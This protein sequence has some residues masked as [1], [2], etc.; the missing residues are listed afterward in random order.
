MS[1]VELLNQPEHFGCFVY[2][3]H[4]QPL[5]NCVTKRKG[6]KLKLNHRTNRIVFLLNGK[7]TYSF[8]TMVN[9]VFKPSTFRLFP[10]SY[11]VLVHIEED[12]TVLYVNMPSK[13]NFC[14][15]FSLEMLYKLNTGIEN[16]TDSYPL[17]MNEVIY[18]YLKSIQSAVDD[19]LKCSYYH[20]LKQKE[21]LFYL[22]AYYPK[23]D[24][25]AFFAP[26]LSSDISFSE[27]IFNS[28]DSVSTIEQLAKITNYSLS[29]FKKRFLKVFGMPPYK[30]FAREKAKRIY[31]TINCTTKT[32]KEI[33][34]EFDF[35]SSAHFT[36]FCKRLFGHS[37]K[38]IREQNINNLK[39]C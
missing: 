36:T 38:E 7:M 29:G 12:S 32:F 3:N 8:N 31:H 17:K 21:L 25:L 4:G 20:E 28:L 37:P 11:D 22:R 1:K 10:S 27:L 30:W 19:G 2:D 33:A 26:M 18:D 24:L 6:E 9:E 15:H 39:I 13:I 23:D 34:D 5:I 35:S 14:D 16:Y